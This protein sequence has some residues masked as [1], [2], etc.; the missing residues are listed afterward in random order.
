LKVL[1]SGLGFTLLVTLALVGT[2]GSASWLPGLVMGGAA[3]LVELLA[4]RRLVRGLSGSTSD[5]MLGF[6]AGLVFRLIGVGLFVGLV[7]WDRTVFPPLAT[8]LGYVGVLIPLL[9]LE[10]RLI[11]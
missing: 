4:A 1:L 9:F 2:L 3:T 5:A 6:A 8:A 10:T 7:L 11:R